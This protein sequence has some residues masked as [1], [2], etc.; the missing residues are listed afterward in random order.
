MNKKMVLAE[1]A[2]AFAGARVCRAFLL[3]TTGDPRT[4]FFGLFADFSSADTERA[5]NRVAPVQSQLLKQFRGHND[6]AI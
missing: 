2:T 5:S 1:V 6:G 3:L 4:G